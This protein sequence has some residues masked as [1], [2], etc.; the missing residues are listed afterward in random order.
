MK[1]IVTF[2]LV[3][4][5]FAMSY[6]NAVN[7]KTTDAFTVTTPFVLF[8]FDD[9]QPMSSVSGQSG[10][11]DFDPNDAEAFC[12]VGYIKDEDLHKNGHHMK[13]SYDVESSKPC[14]NGWWTKLNGADLSKFDAVAITIKGDPEKGFS[15]FFKIE[16]KDKER[17]VEYILEDITDKWKQIIV[18]FA[19]FDGDIAS[20]DWKKMNEFVIVFEDWRLKTKSGRYIIDDISFVPKKGEKVP[21]SDVKGGPS[22]NTSK[23]TDVKK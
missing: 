2:V 5:L 7:Y 14:F 13:I 8:D 23:S 3:T 6:V 9:R 22:T 15:D 11:F 18:P 20:M 17:K 10:I 1:K 19:D 21:F 16:L 4:I 12:R